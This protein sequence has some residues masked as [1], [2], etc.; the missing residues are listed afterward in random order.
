MK[1]LLFVLPVVLLACNGS[2]S[3]SN[4]SA[5]NT[6]TVQNAPNEIP[7]A[8]DAL[9]TKIV[10][11]G[12]TISLGGALLQQKDT[13]HFQP[14]ADHLVYFTAPGTTESVTLLLNFAM[15]F[16]PGVYPIVKMN[17]TRKVGTRKE[18]YGAGPR[19]LPKLTNYTIRITECKDLGANDRGGHKWQLSGQFD[20]LIIPADEVA[21]K[22]T[23]NH[24]AQI[25][26]ERGS[27]SNL[28]VEDN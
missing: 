9:P 22:H 2:G 14:G 3:D 23:P 17:L 13:S 18:I 7:G 27:F 8:T 26:I 12:T 16:K 5:S 28:K 19:D 25:K 6:P 20:E 15:A 11:D 10:I 4:S 24:P 21:L 1:R